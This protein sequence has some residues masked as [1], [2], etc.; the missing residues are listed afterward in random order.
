LHNKLPD[1]LWT[2][3]FVECQGYEIDE[4]VIFQDNM[5]VLSL[6]K[7]GKGSCHPSK[8]IKANFFLIR[9]YYK[10]GEIEVQYCP[11]HVG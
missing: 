8:H 7:N 6:E 4:Y 1:V 10:A 2:R 3:Y 11:C 9:D 5:S